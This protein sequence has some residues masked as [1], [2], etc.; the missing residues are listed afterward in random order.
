MRIYLKSKKRIPCPYVEDLPAVCRTC[1]TE[2]VNSPNFKEILDG[3]ADCECANTDA[4]E[5]LSAQFSRLLGCLP[6]PHMFIRK[7]K[8]FF[9]AGGGRIL[10][11][12]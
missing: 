3:E 8:A 5:I 12:S 2:A 7:Y 9:K 6:L 1:F 4:S 10:I 11:E